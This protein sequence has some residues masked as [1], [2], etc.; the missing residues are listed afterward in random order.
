MSNLPIHGTCAKCQQPV[1]PPGILGL[2]PEMK[3]RYLVEIGVI[4]V[5]HGKDIEG[6]CICADCTI[7]ED[8]VTLGHDDIMNIS[9]RNPAGF[10]C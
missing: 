3:R 1:L 8:G 2:D 4:P 5:Y 9:H 7:G 10:E 6:G